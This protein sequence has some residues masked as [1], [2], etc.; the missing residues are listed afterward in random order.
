M[1]YLTVYEGVGIGGDKLL[2][3]QLKF[4]MITSRK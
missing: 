4:V 2:V 3:F 1:A